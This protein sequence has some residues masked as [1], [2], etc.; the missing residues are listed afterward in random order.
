MWGHTR[1]AKMRERGR[2]QGQGREGR[3]RE[4]GLGWKSVCSNLKS[5]KALKCLPVT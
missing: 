1:R 4:G 5:Q 2:K 3:E